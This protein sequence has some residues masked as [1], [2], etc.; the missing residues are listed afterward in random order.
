M[1][2]EC[3]PYQLGIVILLVLVAIL[4]VINSRLK[5]KIANYQE[6]RNMLIHNAYFNP[7]TDLPNRA[8]IELIIAEHIDRALRHNQTFF[9]VSIK[10][11]NYF[12]IKSRSEELAQKYITEASYRL[13]EAIRE[14]DILGHI[15]ED[16]FLLVFNEYLDEENLSIVLNRIKEALHK[17]PYSQEKY[18]IEYETG[19]GIS[20]FPDH[21]TDSTLLLQRAT[22]EALK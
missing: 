4:F 20:K 16:G 14:E 2:V 22:K 8:N 17:E 9:I 15:S 3:L 6:N 7:V 5:K 1:S 13:L 18:E 19:I 12:H 11:L 21:G 10:I